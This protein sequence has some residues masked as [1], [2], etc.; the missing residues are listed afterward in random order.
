MSLIGVM[1]DRDGGILL[2]NDFLLDLTGWARAEAIGR[3][4][5]DLFLPEDVRGSAR[6]IFRQT[7][8]TGVFPAHSRSEIVTR[9]GRR[10]TIG[11]NNTVFCNDEGRVENVTIIGEDITER[12]RAEEELRLDDMRLE[13]LLRLNQMTDAGIQEITSFALEQAVRLTGSHIGYL[14]FASEDESVLTMHA[15]SSAAMAECRMQEMPRIYQVSETGLWG[16]T[17]APAAADHHQR[18]RGPPPGQEGLPRGSRARRPPP[19]GPGHGRGA[20]RHR[21][22]GG[23]QESDYNESDVRQLNLLMS[24]MWRILQRKR[25][26]EALKESE[27]RFRTAFENASSACPW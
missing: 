18:V 6:H 23:Q 15:W 20:D 13:A 16:G 10:R 1:L 19:G 26:E 17:R 5:F 7:V 24:G 3:N 25:A 27:G 21:G 11:W 8:E 2:C 4:W 12:L 22:R 9:D 14:A